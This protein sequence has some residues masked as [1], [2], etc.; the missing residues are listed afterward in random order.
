[1]VG[2]LLLIILFIIRNPRF[3][4]LILDFLLVRVEGDL[5]VD[6]PINFKTFDITIE[7][8]NNILIGHYVFL[9]LFQGIHI[10]LE[11]ER[12]AI[13]SNDLDPVGVVNGFLGSSME[14]NPKVSGFQNSI[15]MNFS[16]KRAIT[17]GKLLR[18]PHNW[19]LLIHH[20][21]GILAPGFTNL[22]QIS[23]IGL[24]M[25]AQSNERYIL[26]FAVNKGTVDVA[27][28]AVNFMDFQFLQNNEDLTLTTIDGKLA[29]G[30]KNVNGAGCTTLDIGP[31]LCL[32]TVRTCSTRLAIYAYGDLEVVGCGHFFGNSVFFVFEFLQQNIYDDQLIWA[33]VFDARA[34]WTRR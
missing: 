28:D 24:K 20:R 3:N 10:A 2:N 4:I 22:F 9:G 27:V 7:N 13:S 33:R 30:W 6:L 12:F 17:K 31:R 26:G 5:K 8:N 11:H 19:W 29:F 21:N 1:L 25:F 34:E 14:V 18:N 15:S 16:E 32:Y 23:M